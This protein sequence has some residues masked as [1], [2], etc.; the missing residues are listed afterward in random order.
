MFIVIS[1]YK[2]LFILKIS[3]KNKA[4]LML[5]KS[6]L[7]IFLRLTYKVVFSIITLDILII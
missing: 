5:K 3:L 1:R 2:N 7:Y 4:M 6:N